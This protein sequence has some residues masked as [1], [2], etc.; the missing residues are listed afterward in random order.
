MKEIITGKHFVLIA[1]VAIVWTLVVIGFSTSMGA[2]PLRMYDWGPPVFAGLITLVVMFLN[3]K[4][5]D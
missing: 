5:Q 2:R 4:R 3:K 1:A